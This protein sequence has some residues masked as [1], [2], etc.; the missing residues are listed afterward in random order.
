MVEQILFL[1]IEI[2]RR[3]LEIMKQKP[4]YILY[5]FGSSDGFRIYFWPIVTVWLFMTLLLFLFLPLEPDSSRE[6]IFVCIGGFACLTFLWFLVFQYRRVKG[7]SVGKRTLVLLSILSTAF[8]FYLAVFV[9]SR[10]LL[11]L[12]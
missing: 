4:P 6:A 2:Q 12:R 8:L 7:K 1:E 10:L 9:L 5:R 3:D 11:L